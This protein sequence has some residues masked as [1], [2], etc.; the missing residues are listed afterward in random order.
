VH[1]LTHQKIHT[2]FW[3]IAINQEVNI[4]NFEELRSYS[5][6]QIDDLPKSTLVNNYL[7]EY[8]F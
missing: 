3:H 2:T 4:N 6:D 5:L 1:I 8:F 7:K